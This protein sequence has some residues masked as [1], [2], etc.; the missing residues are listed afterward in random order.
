MAGAKYARGPEPFR[1]FYDFHNLLPYTQPRLDAGDVH[2][3]RAFL[4]VGLPEKEK[5]KKQVRHFVDTPIKFIIY[6]KLQR[7]YCEKFFALG[8]F[9][10]ACLLLLEMERC[11]A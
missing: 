10:A 6:I 8:L 9:C 11:N 5:S 3:K 2:Q 4:R 7:N 1:N